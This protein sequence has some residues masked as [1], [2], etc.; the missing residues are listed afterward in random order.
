MGRELDTAVVGSTL[1]PDERLPHQK[2]AALIPPEEV[3]R[4]CHH[5]FIVARFQR[6]GKGARAI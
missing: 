1:L 4:D 6:Q 5:D 2:G 3:V